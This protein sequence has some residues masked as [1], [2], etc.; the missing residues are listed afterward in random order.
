VFRDGRH[1]EPHSENA[2]SAEPRIAASIEGRTRSLWRVI[3]VLKR[4]PTTT[5][6]ELR[7]LAATNRIFRFIFG[8][9]LCRRMI[10]SY[11]QKKEITDYDNRIAAHF[12]FH[13][14]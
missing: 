1:V 7:S 6:P 2:T 14:L 5:V 11:L 13:F 10:C 9:A 8:Y 4:T 12:W 3:D